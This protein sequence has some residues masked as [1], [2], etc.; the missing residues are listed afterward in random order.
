MRITK[1]VWNFHIICYCIASGHSSCTAS[2]N[3][4]FISIIIRAVESGAEY[5]SLAAIPGADRTKAR[6][7]GITN[8]SVIEIRKHGRRRVTGKPACAPAVRNLQNIITV[9]EGKGWYR[10]AAKDS[11]SDFVSYDKCPECIPT[12]GKFLAVT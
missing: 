8:T 5:N 2:D 9:D 1:L 12:F 4:K 7:A 11:I 6:A 3:S 10:P